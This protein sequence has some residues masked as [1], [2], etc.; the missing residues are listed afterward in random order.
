[1][2]AE[3]AVPYRVTYITIART[4]RTPNTNAPP[5]T[6]REKLLNSVCRLV[7]SAKT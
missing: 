2:G 6:L 7:V 4:P 1:M 5:L 3:H